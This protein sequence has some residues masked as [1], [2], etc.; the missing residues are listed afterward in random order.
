MM[1]HEYLHT[2]TGGFRTTLED[3]F[4]VQQQTDSKVGNGIGALDI[5]SSPYGANGKDD[6][7]FPTHLSP[8]SK[9]ALG[10]VEP[11]LLNTATEETNTYT[12]RPSELYGDVL[13]I[14]LEP[15]GREYLLLEY[16]Q[17]ILFD[18]HLPVQGLCMYHIDATVSTEN[19]RAGYPSD[20][21][22]TTT[23]TSSSSSND[24][25]QNAH[26]YKVA[27]VQRDGRYDLEKAS[28]MGDAGDCFG[29][30]TKLGPNQDGRTFPNT[31][32]YGEA[33]GVMSTGVVVEVLE[34]T[35]DT[36]LISVTIPDGLRGA[37]PKPEDVDV[38]EP[39]ST[40]DVISGKFPNTLST[41][42]VLAA[43]EAEARDPPREGNGDLQPGL[44]ESSVSAEARDNFLL[45]EFD[46]ANDELQPMDLPASLFSANSRESSIVTTTVAPDDEGTPV[47]GTGPVLETAVEQVSNVTILDED[48]QDNVLTNLFTNTTK[49]PKEGGKTEG[50]SDVA[51]STVQEYN[52]AQSDNQAIYNTDGQQGGKSE[53]ALNDQNAP[54]L[55]SML[56]S[57]GPSRKYSAWRLV[58]MATIFILQ[59]N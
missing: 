40:T 27:L 50:E 34:Q 29:V 16:R 14:N 39:A 33:V 11:T 44:G 28:N 4:D 5:M 3:L 19:N 6:D 21:T 52:E 37:P 59:L 47:A 8:Y 58:G 13:R 36:I 49:G 2:A 12:L 48:S 9:I 57:A 38:P 54:G 32:T 20:D 53:A 35:G 23:T 45:T 55:T 51:P 30:G 41:S 1:T 43:P 18:I 31:D 26:H 15:S 10:W 56:F 22:T 42:Q 17:P 46:E 24:W 25:P 7:D